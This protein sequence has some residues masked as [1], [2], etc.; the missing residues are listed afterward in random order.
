VAKAKST[1]KKAKQENAIVR[2]LRETRAE[3]RKVHWPTREEAWNLTR[4][5]MAVTVAMAALLA[6]L[7]H[8]FAL[9]LEGLI[10]GNATAIGALILA[11]VASALIAVIL[12]R[13]AA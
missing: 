8:L 12:R 5:V 11:I 2:Y 10:S 1:K 13:Q 6:I 7:D 9:E 4:I 3:L